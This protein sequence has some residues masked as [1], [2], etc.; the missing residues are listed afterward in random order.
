MKKKIFIDTDIILDVVFKREPFFVDSQKIIAS[1][2]KNRFKGFTSSLIIANCFYI[3]SR[4][5]NKN[6]AEKTIAKLRSIMTILPFTDKEIGESL[7]SG[8]K[9]FEDGVQ[10]FIAANNVVNTIITRNIAD[11]K[12][13]DID[14]FMPKDF[15]TLDL[16]K[17][18]KEP[19]NQTKYTKS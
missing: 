4:N 5:K 18:G 12:N 16:I 7:N 19:T 14:V 1:I 13:V 2:E 9:D 3:I 6:I 15:L 11:F 8:F 17:K 10:Y